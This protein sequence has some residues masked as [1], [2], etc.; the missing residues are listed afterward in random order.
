MPDLND[1][2]GVQ[3]LRAR[4]QG[5][6]R[7][8]VAVLDGLADISH[9]TFEGADVESVRGYWLDDRPSSEFPRDHATHITSLIF[10]QPGTEVEGLA[11]RS[12]GLFLTT[13]VDEDS[14]ESELNLARAIE[15]ALS[16]GAQIIH[17]AFCHPNQTGKARDWVIEA[18]RKAERAGAVII[19]PAGNDYGENWCVPSSLPEVL[20]V[21]AL[22][23][24]GAP[25]AFTN[26][27]ELYAGHSIMGPGENVLGATPGEGT[28]SQKGTS[29]AAPVLTGLITALTSAVVQA[30]QPIQPQRVRDVLIATARPCTGAGASRCIGGVVAVDRA[31]A[32]LLDGM[33]IEQARQHFPDGPLAPDAPGA[34]DTP[35]K[36]AHLPLPPHSNARHHTTL[37]PKPR[38]AYKR[39]EP[40]DAQPAAQPSA[41]EP[42][43]RYPAYFYGIGAVDYEFPDELTKDS[44]TREMRAQV[45]HG[46]VDDRVKVIDYLDQNPAE[47][48]RLLWTF[49]INDERRYVITPVGAYGSGVYD[50]LAAL[51]LGRVRGDIAIASLPGIVTDEITI[52]VDGTP[53]RRL[54]VPSLRGVYGWKAEQVATQ[55]LTAVHNDAMAGGVG[56][57]EAP[58]PATMTATTAVASDDSDTAVLGLR[59]SPVVIWPRL[60]EEVTPQIQGAVIDFLNQIYFR[61]A[62]QP[63]VSRDRAVSFVATNGYQVSAAFLD[64]MHDGLQYLDFRT[65]YSP[66][67]RV[68]GQCWDVIVRFNDP[69]SARRAPREYRMTVDIADV[70]PV[71]VGRLRRWST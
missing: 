47:A 27:G 58:L 50:M 55:S 20:A 67:A 30:G 44:F 10:G 35:P 65:E 43:L 1:L 71:T 5:D 56:T 12:R 14:A 42:S 48:R 3:A 37:P 4:T 63:D 31:M 39:P 53:L 11:P 2:P 51:T 38:E 36:V 57:K 32:V 7:I 15:F 34:L 24:D 41:I 62:Q 52:A 19:A 69:T 54:K 17:C 40:E 59:E 61:A 68:S 66:F 29:V 16:K 26:F 33:T 49:A 25:M 28:A 23:D 8:L 60:R 70:M 22:A 18:V 6:S 13:G 64:A 46:D 45:G 21:G 9:A